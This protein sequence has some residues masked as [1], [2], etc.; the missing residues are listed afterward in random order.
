MD[1]SPGHPGRLP[2]VKIKRAVGLVA[3]AS[4][5]FPGGFRSGFPLPRMLHRIDI[6]GRG[7]NCPWCVDFGGLCGDD[8]VDI[9]NF[10]DDG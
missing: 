9:F 2:G 4:C 1:V 5:H 8:L 6:V 7:E 10:F 3:A